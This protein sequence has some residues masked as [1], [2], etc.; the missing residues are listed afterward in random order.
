M[1]SATFSVVLVKGEKREVYGSGYDQDAANKT[2][3]LHKG[4]GYWDSVEI[5]A[6]PCDTRSLAQEAIETAKGML[7]IPCA[8][9]SSAVV[10]IQD[11]ESLFERG[12]FRFSA[13]RAIKGV[14]YIVGV[15]HPT[16]RTMHSRL[17]S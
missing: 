1:V 10:C 14:S 12:E 13:I 3:S 5:I 8:M 16:Y 17:N 7:D 15:L 9:K 11:A 2:A 6:D 4:N